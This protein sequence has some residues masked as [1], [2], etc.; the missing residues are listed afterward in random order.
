[1]QRLRC[2]GNRFAWPNTAP[3]AAPKNKSIEYP[4]SSMAIGSVNATT[5]ASSGDDRVADTGTTDSTKVAEKTDEEILF[6]RFLQAQWER[7][8][9]SFNKI[10]QKL[11]A[12][13][14]AT[15]PDDVSE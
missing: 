13:I 3:P 1:L 15:D 6:E 10:V 14:K 9:S 4:E 8:Y 11:R 2:A 7:Q 12:S 5:T